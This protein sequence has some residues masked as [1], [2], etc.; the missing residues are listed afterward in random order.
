[1]KVVDVAEFYTDKG[2]G[3][4]TYINQK[5]HAA[6]RLG[7]EMV[8]IAPGT[9]SYEE[10]RHGGRVIWIKGPKLPFD[11]RY[12]I[13]WNKKKVHRIL[14]REKPDIIEGSSLW[15]GGNFAGSWS[16][17]AIKSLIF[18][19]DPVAVYPHTLLGNVIKNDSIDRMFGF[20]WKYI[21]RLSKKYDTTIVSGDWLKNRLM[22]FDIKNPVAVPFGIDKTS[23]S[24]D[25]RDLVLRSKLL[26][27]LG[28]PGDAHL[29][30]SVG[31]YHPEKRLSTIIKGFKE[32]SKHKPMG[33]I[34]Y[35]SG[36]LKSWIEWKVSGVPRLKLMGFTA[37]REELS[38][39]LASCDYFVHGSAAE[40]FGIAV[41]EAICSGLPI[42]VP[43]SG[44][45]AEF[46]NPLYSEVYSTGDSRSLANALL[47]IVSRD[48]EKMAGCCQKESVSAVRTIDEHFDHL[49]SY[50][51]SLLE[52]KRNELVIS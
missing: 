14:D 51:Q 24:P 47:S 30:V 29:F 18:H 33:L 2:G 27:E 45:A 48:R 42:I 28:L 10:K 17:E 1:M 25:K 52:E 32:A 26:S 40:T 43:D 23:F 50:Y 37:N 36:P 3:V 12:V 34:M 41:A 39:I 9:K 11:T 31:R 13:L 19:Q 46:A 22:H 35:G 44:G 20:F 6:A 16:G 15:T 49:F 5:L 21:K 8:I 38:H 4:K 7:H